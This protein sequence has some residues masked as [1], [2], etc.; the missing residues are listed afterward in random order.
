MPPT[1]NEAEASRQPPVQRRGAVHPLLDLLAAYS[2]RVLVVAAATVALIALLARLRIVVVALVVALLLSRA[3]IVPAS[4]L[5]RRRWPRIL[6]AAASVVSFLVLLAAAFALIGASVADELDDLGPTIGTAVDDVERWLVEDSPFDLN[7]GDIRRIRQDMGEAVRSSLGSSGGAVVSGAILV[8]EA[9]VGVLLGI[10]VT[11]FALKDGDRFLTWA[12]GLLPAPR[13]EL[14]DVLARRA[15]TTLGGYLR[16]AAL[17][18]VIEGTVIAVTLAL[19]GAKLAVPVGLLTFMAAFV[20]FVGAI[21]AGVVAVLVAL[22]TAGFGAAVIVV[23]VAVLL[24]QFDND[25]LAPVVY[26]RALSLH[27]VVVLLG[28]MTGGAL[29]GLAGTFLAVPFTAVAVNLVSAAKEYHAGGPSPP[30]D[31]P[32]ATDHHP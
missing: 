8:V 24:Q 13:R 31:E 32:E 21:V 6:A 22:A 9:L 11:V 17:L 12:R 29:F 7:G 30:G 27:P 18:G 4:W 2:W 20:P 10:I 14:G 25:L 19:V 26:G 16:G 15:W 1:A 28:I 5:R 3:L 23:I